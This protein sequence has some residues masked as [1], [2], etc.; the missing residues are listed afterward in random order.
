MSS[1]RPLAGTLVRT[2]ELEV[3]GHRRTALEVAPAPEGAPPERLVLAVH[4][5]NQSP[6]GFRATTARALDALAVDGSSVVVYP[7]SWRG[8]LWND[9]RASTPSRARRD[10][11]DDVALLRALV[12]RYRERGVRRVEAVGFSNGG[13]LLVRALRDAPELLDAVVLVGATLPAEGNLLPALSTPRAVPTALVHGTRDP[14]VPFGGG[15]A[16]LFGL[17]PRGAVR[18]F[19]E[20]VQHFVDEAGHTEPP[21]TTVLP[22]RRRSG[23][24]TTRTLHASP[25]RP[26]VS[27]FTVDGGGHTF[28]VRG[29]RLPVPVGRT[30]PDV[31]IAEVLRELDGPRQV[32]A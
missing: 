6:A 8:G 2:T 24:T 3:D 21:R 23:T 11:V 20:T 18:S 15:E 19:A 5:S 28:P 31:D 10:G 13:Q 9:A 4:G 26:P 17:R 14:V 25:G 27:S 29:R 16:S 22:R 30:S 32:G 12:G 1:R 7:A